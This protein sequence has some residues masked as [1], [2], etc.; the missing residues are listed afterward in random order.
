[1]K[2]CKHYR[3]LIKYLNSISLFINFV[4]NAYVCNKLIILGCGLIASGPLILSKPMLTGA[5]GIIWIIIYVDNYHSN[6]TAL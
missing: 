6:P 5:F 4:P 3:S 1:M 2:G